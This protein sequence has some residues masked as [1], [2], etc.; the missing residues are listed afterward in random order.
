MALT[1]IKT[2]VR[3]TREARA[4]TGAL[5]DG[6]EK[7]IAGVGFWFLV[8]F[9]L[10]KDGADVFL[11]GTL[12]LSIVAFFITIVAYAAFLFYLSWKGVPV[13]GTRRLA[14]YII[15]LAI[16]LIPVLG[17][18]PMF[19]AMVFVVRTLENNRVLRGVARS[20]RGGRI[21]NL[22]DLR[23]EITEAV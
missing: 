21:T 19:T 15:T 22:T 6:H 17:G 1:E 14:T 7:K 11:H 10:A 18:L 5:T 23:K 2:G 9:S 3:Y 8:M 12:V 13:L 20:A 4:V 16:E